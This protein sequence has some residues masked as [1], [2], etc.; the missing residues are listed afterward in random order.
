MAKNE[1]P[2]GFE[3]E[4]L[5]PGFELEAPEAPLRDAAAQETESPGGQLGQA[6]G[7]SLDALAQVLR[8]IFMPRV[9]AEVSREIREAA[10][11]FKAGVA[12]DTAPPGVSARIGELLGSVGL[13]L[14]GGT[15]AAALTRTPTGARAG[16]A[17]AT[18]IAA[19][20]LGAGAGEA[21]RGLSARALA[22]G[23]PIPI[24]EQARQLVKTSLTAGV[25]EGSLGAAGAAFRVLRPGM[26]KSGAQLLRGLSGVSEKHARAVLGNP[27][28][29]SQ[30]PTLEAAQQIYGAAVKGLPGAREYLE[31]TTGDILLQPGDA[32]KMV[33]QTLEAVR[34]KSTSL[35]QV[36]AARQANSMLLQAAKFGDPSQ[37]ANLAGMLKA[38]DTFDEILE[39]GLPGFKHASRTYFEA[40]AREAFRS[41][42]PQNKN[43]SPNALRLMGQFSVLGAAALLKA[44]GVI[45]AALPISPR[46][47]GAAIRAGF[48]LGQAAEKL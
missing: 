9:P 3:F 2:P 43:L 19:Q 45:L 27:R 10:E 21:A 28:I 7:A 46:F 31:Q 29:L 13:P 16:A 42:F 37:R 30:A 15:A 48:R 26:I 40:N 38:R 22:P 8:G 39:S 17:L 18:R 25:T 6:S 34:E 11:G 47:Q 5:P 33:N 35:G 24:K 4:S 14:A 1:L 32:V 36:L 20:T 23:R 41:V 12:G 44:P